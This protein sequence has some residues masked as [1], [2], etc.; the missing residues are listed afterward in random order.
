M[1]RW[2]IDNG[3]SAGVPEGIGGNDVADLIITAPVKG[4][5]AP[6]TEVP[7]PVFADRMM[8]DG[9]AIHPAG[10]TVHAPC[11]GVVAT[12]HAARHA[13]TI[14]SP[15]G[16]EILIHV[17]LET[18]VLGGKGFRALVAAGDSVAAGDPIIEF[19][20]D[21]VGLAAAGLVTPVVVVNSD[22]FH[23]EKRITGQMVEPGDPLMTLTPIGGEQ[24]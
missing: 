16:A 9:V 1:D 4:W 18:V 7:D 21:E 12:L 22:A 24:H 19:D 2:R 11:D 3:M 5:A 6:L 8:G 15:E 13:V 10:S 20:L 14:R 17:G 23:V